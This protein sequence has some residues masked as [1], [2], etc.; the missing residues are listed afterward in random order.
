MSPATC[1]EDGTKTDR[2]LANRA[3]ANASVCDDISL[4]VGLELLDGMY[5]P[6]DVLAL[7]FVDSA[8]RPGG[9]ETKDG[10][11]VR[12]PLAS[13]VALGA[14]EPHGIGDEQIV[15]HSSVAW[16]SKRA[17]EKVTESRFDMRGRAEAE[18]E[19]PHTRPPLPGTPVNSLAFPPLP[20]SLSLDFF[21]LSTLCSTSLAFNC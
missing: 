2:N 9:N 14:V 20:R 15:I 21:P 17:R 5:A 16:S 10:V 4:L 3:L 19:P 18:Q 1:A 6:V 7:G 8:I 11:L 13:A 12:Y